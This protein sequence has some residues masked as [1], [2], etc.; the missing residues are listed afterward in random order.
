MEGSDSS[1]EV[2]QRYTIQVCFSEEASLDESLEI[3]Q[4]KYYNSMT[5]A[6]ID[7]SSP[8]STARLTLFDDERSI[9]DDI[10]E[11][12][13]SR[14]NSL[15]KQEK[16]SVFYFLGQRRIFFNLL[17]LTFIW[18]SASFNYYMINLQVKYFPGV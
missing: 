15:V 17:F 1:P 3:I 6:S 16:P 18:T 5:V 4:K 12:D 9:A 11:L 10:S 8:P 2:S 13:E 7:R 14:A